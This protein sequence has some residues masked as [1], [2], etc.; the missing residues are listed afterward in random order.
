MRQLFA[1]MLVFCLWLGFVPSASADVS[2]LVPC[3]EVPAFTQRLNNSVNGQQARLKKYDANS[4]SAAIIKGR[5]DQTK[6]RFASYEAMLCGPEG[7]PRLI[8]DGRL[9]HAGDF[10]I[11]GLIFL[12]LAGWLGWSGRTY[13]I[14]TKKGDSPELKEIQID[15]P[16][17]IQ[18]FLTSLT[19]PLLAAKE[20]LSGEIQE[21]DNKIPVSPR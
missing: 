13:Q 7:L 4:A 14:A 9:S 10:I 3:K 15:V 21:A 18:S 16:L 11:P 19:W 8:V 12:Y 17:A 6:K 5:I 2:G 20:I 1:L